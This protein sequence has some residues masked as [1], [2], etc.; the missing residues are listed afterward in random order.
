MNTNRAAGWPLVPCLLLCL[1]FG[2]LA[3]C[4]PPRP[5]VTSASPSPATTRETI[6]AVGAAITR[7]ASASEG[8]VLPGRA[9]AARASD[10]WAVAED[11]ATRIFRAMHPKLVACYAR[12]L[13][14][15]PDAH[16]HL[17]VDVLVGADGRPRDVSTSGGAALGSEA[18]DCMVRQVRRAVFVPPEHGGTSR[19]RVPFTFRPASGADDGREPGG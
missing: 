2:L 12:R 17:V 3:G 14:S 9:H 16:A 8:N 18:V 10:P 4:S 5:A 6:A 15:R 19:V 13:A 1:L 11:D 7:S